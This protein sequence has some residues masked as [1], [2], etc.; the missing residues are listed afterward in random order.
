[1]VASTIANFL[2]ARAGCACATPPR[3]AVTA[4]DSAIC[5]R[6]LL[7]M[8]SSSPLCHSCTDC[9]AQC[10]VSTRISISFSNP[11]TIP[12]ISLSVSI[13]QSFRL[14]SFAYDAHYTAVLRHFKKE[15][16]QSYRSQRNRWEDSKTFSFKGTTQLAGSVGQYEC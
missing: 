15:T 9:M 8:V 13:S 10:F 12:Y 5:C 2:A 4:N 7:C 11:S 16:P 3:Q 14:C 1:M 6:C